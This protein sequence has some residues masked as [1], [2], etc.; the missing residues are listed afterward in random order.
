MSKNRQNQNRPASKPVELREPI[1]EYTPIEKAAGLGSMSLEEYAEACAP[2][3]API[4]EPPVYSSE[5]AAADP[6]LFGVLVKGHDVRSAKVYVMGSS[7]DLDRA[8]A[9]MQMLG[10]DRITHDWVKVIQSQ[11]L[12]DHSLSRNQCRKFALEDLEG[13]DAADVVLALLPTDR[14]PSTGH[15]FEFGYAYK[16]CKPIITAGTR[17]GI[18]WALGDKHF[19]SDAEAIAFLRGVA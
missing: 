1:A 7:R 6:D 11:M 10:Y 5:G 19:G 16:S 15:W 12:P 13:V 3:V 14:T 18:F 4:I 17:K 8:R 2:V 9:A